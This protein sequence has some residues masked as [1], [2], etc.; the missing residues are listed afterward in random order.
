MCDTEQVK[1]L[2]VTE[3]VEYFHERIKEVFNF[4]PSQNCFILKTDYECASM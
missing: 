4:S 2:E 3:L 1:E